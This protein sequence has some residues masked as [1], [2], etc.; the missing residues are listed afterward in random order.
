MASEIPAERRRALLDDFYAECDELLTAM[1]EGLA[2]WLA[3]GDV[4]PAAVVLE[5]LF[6]HAHTLKG[7]SAIA[8]LRTAE[9]LAHGMEDVLR[10]I[11]KNQLVPDRA[12][13]EA[14]EAGTQRLEQIVGAHRH[15]R[16]A[17]EIG[18]LLEHYR[19][20]LGAARP[21]N[22]SFPVPEAAPAPSTSTDPVGS[23]AIFVPSKELDAR[24]INVSTVRQKISG[25]GRIVQAAPR[26]LG[27]GAMQFEFKVAAPVPDDAA[28]WAADGVTWQAAGVVGETVSPPEGASDALTLTPSHIIRVD[29]ARLDDLMRIT[30]ELVIHRSR[31]ED[32][33]RQIEHAP[34]GLK[35]ASL[36]LGRSLREMRTAITQARLVP[37]A[38]IF[39][40]MPYVVRDLMRESTKKVRVVLEGGQTEIDKFL[41]ERLKEPLLHLVRN[42]FAHGIELPATRLAAG[43]PEEATLRLQAESDG[44][45]VVIRVSDDGAGI[46]VDDVATRALRQGLT[47]PPTLDARGLLELICTRG[48]STREEADLA[49]GRGVGMAVVADSVRRHGGTLGL[50]TTLGRGTVFTLRLPLSLSIADAIIVA[51]GSERC[52]IPMGAVNEIIQV[53]AERLRTINREEIVPY[54]DGLLPVRR[55]RNLFRQA[56]DAPDP[57]TILVVA[58]ERGAAGLV[59]DRVLAQREIVVRPLTDPLLRLRGVTGAT[60]LG[61]GRPLLILDPAPFTDGAVRPPVASPVFASP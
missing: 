20:M 35:E 46:D 11:S 4:A 49:S 15:G 41:V 1:R 23:I 37:I 8:G 52:A 28:N 32:I 22:P 34:E 18:D 27:P 45:S 56:P 54:R 10:S 50:E 24:G 61:D 48:F 36:A 38:E 60:E 42:A 40:R 43:K 39:T 57:L 55:L 19:Q 6:R 33:F 44:D 53:P 29:L 51:V 21:A 30:G 31:L 17:P 5:D 3:A 14:L 47:L 9:E 7:N 26:I 12:I 13:A 2:A 58:S 25:L 16:T 59:V